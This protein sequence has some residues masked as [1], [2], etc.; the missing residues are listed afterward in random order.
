MS[1]HDDG[2]YSVQLRHCNDPSQDETSQ[3][4]AVG[5][6]H[7]L[8]KTGAGCQWPRICALIFCEPLHDGHDRL[9]CGA[10]G[11]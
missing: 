6:G 11:G 1:D 10:F 2:L 8:A 3:D 5:M 9:Q 4:Q 7:A